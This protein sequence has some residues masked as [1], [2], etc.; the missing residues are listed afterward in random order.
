MKILFIGKVKSSLKYL[1]QLIKLKQNI[2]GVITD[3]KKRINSDYLDLKPFCKTKK[4]SINI[5]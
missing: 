2:V 5:C 1:K 4:N 3:N